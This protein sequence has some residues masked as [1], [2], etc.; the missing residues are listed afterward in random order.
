MECIASSASNHTAI[1]IACSAPPHCVKHPQPAADNEVAAS[2]DKPPA[3]LSLLA[4]ELRRK[5]AYC[6]HPA[7]PGESVDPASSAWPR[8]PEPVHAAR[9]ARQ[10]DDSCGIASA[11]RHLHP[12]APAACGYAAAQRE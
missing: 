6:R 10:V 1:V 5:Q 3:P 2:S 4:I 7:A 9:Q 8:Y 12:A 11:E